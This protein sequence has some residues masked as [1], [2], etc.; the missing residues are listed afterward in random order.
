MNFKSSKA[1]LSL[2][3]A[4]V[5]LQS[6][7]QNIEEQQQGNHQAEIKNAAPLQ[8]SEL[9]FQLQLMK[10]EVLMPPVYRLYY[11]FIDSGNWLGIRVAM[12]DQHTNFIYASTSIIN[13]EKIHMYAVKF[14]PDSIDTHSFTG[15]IEWLDL[16][17]NTLYGVQYT[18]NY[19]DKWLQPIKVPFE[20]DS[21]QIAESSLLRYPNGEENPPHFSRAR[22]KYYQGILEWCCSFSGN[23]EA[24]SRCN[25]IKVRE[26]RIP[27]NLGVFYSA[28]FKSY[29]A[30]KYGSGG[31]GPGLGT[32]A[33]NGINPWLANRNHGLIPQSG[34]LWTSWFPFYTGSMYW[35]NYIRL[36]IK[37]GTTMYPQ[38]GIIEEQ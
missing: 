22:L 4:L 17:T 9:Q 6:C 25:Q 24:Q 16:Q 3:I 31:F 23:C 29:Y 2:S 20:R 14:F 28:N 10:V 30:G 34:N 27:R 15:Q 26:G 37:P 1:I 5:C 11:D 38:L 12:N 33:L 18:D 19:Q 36:D 8:I 7:S 32:G 13:P 35:V 21:M